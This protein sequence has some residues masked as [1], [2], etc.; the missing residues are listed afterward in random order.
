MHSEKSSER[1]G[2]QSACISTV[3]FCFIIYDVS[4]Q[5]QPLIG[6]ADDGVYLTLSD[7]KKLGLQSKGQKIETRRGSCEMYEQDDLFVF[8]TA[9]NISFL[10]LLWCIFSLRNRLPR[11]CDQLQHS[12]CFRFAS[13]HHIRRSRNELLKRGSHRSPSNRP[14]RGV[15]PLQ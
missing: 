15:W 11:R 3:V 5:I 13:Q 14:P 1:S 9:S 4:E 8:L 10:Q 7:I 6:T 12:A 2:G